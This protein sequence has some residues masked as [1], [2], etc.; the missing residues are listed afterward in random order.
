MTI[1]I[2]QGS[3]LGPTL[4]LI[5][6]NDISEYIPNGICNIF[7]DDVVIYVTAKN[8]TD[9]NLQLQENLNEVNKWYL[10]NRLRINIEKTKVMLL[11]AQSFDQLNISIEGKAL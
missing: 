8:T 1:G 3:A 2:P 6:I 7:A 4:F 11:K 5:F 10:S 9:V